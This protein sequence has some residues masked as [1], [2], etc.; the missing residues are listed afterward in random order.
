MK[1]WGSEAR[2][3]KVK[4][5]ASK[6]VHNVVFV[7]YVYPATCKP[8]LAAALKGDP[9]PDACPRCGPGSGQYRCTK[10]LR[11]SQGG[12]QGFLAHG[13]DMHDPLSNLPNQ[14]GSGRYNNL[15]TAG[16][17]PTDDEEEE[18]DA[19]ISTAGMTGWNSSKPTIVMA[20]LAGISCADT[21]TV[22]PSRGAR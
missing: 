8:C 7:P 2:G 21:G 13:C 14:R 22:G 9:M 18:A 11:R 3:R 5:F 1:S 10:C 6:Y 16:D 17:E 4:T 12:A 19:T 15:R 20:R